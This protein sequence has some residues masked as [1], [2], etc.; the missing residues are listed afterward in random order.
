MHWTLMFGNI[1]VMPFL[2]HTPS[3]SVGRRLRY[4]MPQ[5]VT[6]RRY[7]SVWTVLLKMH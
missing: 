7:C 3:G 2:E 4:Y 1:G 5:S 6:G